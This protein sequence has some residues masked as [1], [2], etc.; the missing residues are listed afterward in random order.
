MMNFNETNN[1][2]TKKLQSNTPFNLI[3]L[4]NTAGYIMN[5]LFKKIN[6]SSE[7]FSD[8]T[9]LQG[10]I[11]PNSCEYYLEHVTP[12]LLE[13]M[14]AADI[15]SVVDVAGEIESGNFF[16]NFPS[17]PFKYAGKYGH[18][19]LDPGALL[20]HSHLD[21]LDCPW[22]ANLKNKKVLVISTHR[23]SILR[24]WENID[25]IWGSNRDLIA[26]FDLI[27]VIRSP[28]HPLMD[29]RQPPNCEHWLQSVD[30]IKDLIDTYEYDVLLS[31]SSS[32]SPFYVHHAKMNGKIGIQLGGVH[33]LFFGITGYRWNQGEYSP[34]KN[35]YNE[36]WIFPLEIDEAQKRKKLLQLESNFAYW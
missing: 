1:V 2:I 20:G 3:R 31:G 18:Y 22:T 35:M 24:Q 16:E 25:K 8:V 5:C 36:H 17:V 34:W 13:T 23:E 21:K 26:P 28:Y 32:S 15:L 12:R 27:D 19:I 9:L 11:Y 10:G 6:P 7:F 30:Y 29:D 14:Y 4:D 33:Q